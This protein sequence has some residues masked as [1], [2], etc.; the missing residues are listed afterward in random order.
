VSV[1]DKSSENKY[2]NL[3]A[4]R[5]AGAVARGIGAPTQKM[6]AFTYGLPDEDS[7][8]FNDLAAAATKTIMEDGKTIFQYG[9]PRTLAAYI[10]ESLR[11]EEDTTIA[12]TQIAVTAGSSQA[13]SLVARVLL[14][15]GD[16]ILCEEFTWNGALHIFKNAETTVIPVEMDEGGLI[17]E[18]VEAKIL[19]LQAQGIKPKFIYTIPTFQNPTGSTMSV[20]RRLALL[21]IAEKYDTLI[22]EDHAYHGLAFEGDTPPT[23][24][25]LDHER[26]LGRVL[27]CR[28]FSK[29]LAAGMRLG[30]VAG[31]ED[32]MVRLTGLKD[33]GGTN[34]F[35]GYIAA[36]YA[37]EN[38]LRNHIQDLVK[39][40]RQRRDLMV[41][42]LDK[43][44]AGTGVTWNVPAGGFF[45]WLKLPEGLDSGALLPKAQEAG[46]NY[47]PGTSVVPQGVDGKSYIRLSYSFVK[48]EEIEPGVAALAKTIKESLA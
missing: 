38:R 21:D 13:I 33:D 11:L 15:P 46:V 42:A 36:T 19:E 3:L 30:W 31:P 14:D 47:L 9:A 1:A 28:T 44:L 37:Q 6:I 40:Y 29:I 12:P 45:I 20:E 24:F 7:F 43:H 41:A 23:L 32:L 17:P 2:D 4:K 10:L 16:V 26:K 35:A 39:I 8:P 5:A 48:D 18:K 25:T 34:P 27:H 22:L